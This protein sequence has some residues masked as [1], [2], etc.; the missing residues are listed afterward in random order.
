[1]DNVEEHYTAYRSLLYT[2]YSS[3]VSNAE[4]LNKAPKSLT[5]VN[6]SKKERHNGSSLQK[7][8]LVNLHGMESC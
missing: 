1:M 3:S 8:I 5:K 6:A 2:L 4:N 7:Y